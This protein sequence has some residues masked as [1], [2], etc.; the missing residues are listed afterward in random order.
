[1]A[2]D[3]ERIRDVLFDEHIALALAELESG[4]QKIERL[5]DVASMD[6]DVLVERLE[7]VVQ[8]G[9]LHC[10]DGVYSADSEKLEEFLSHD[11]QF[12][13]VMSSITEMDSYL[14]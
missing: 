14:N 1:M 5:A 4:P 12:D 8:C 11:G 13:N 9:F 10:N 2:Y 7:Y 3:V 6:A